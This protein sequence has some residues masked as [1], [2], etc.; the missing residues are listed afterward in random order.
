[1][2]LFPSI[3]SAPLRF[4]AS[5]LAGVAAPT[6]AFSLLALCLGVLPPLA[7]LLGTLPMSALMSLLATA[8]WFIGPSESKLTRWIVG[9]FIPVALA[10]EASAFLMLINSGSN[11][12]FDGWFVVGNVAWALVA[13]VAAIAT[14]DRLSVHADCQ[15][16]SKTSGNSNRS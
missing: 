8:C 12:R 1:M 2:R 4:V 6:L 5:A 11:S 15:R 3:A 10:F 7:L 16:D 13:S 14:A 9:L